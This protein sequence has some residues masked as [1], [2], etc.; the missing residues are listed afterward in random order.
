[1]LTR[2][3]IL[4]ALLAAGLV[5]A[6]CSEQ[7]VDKEPTAQ[8]QSVVVEGSLGSIPAVSLPDGM[9]VTNREELQAIPGFGRELGAG[10]TAIL[11]VTTF[12]GEGTL[13]EGP[14]LGTPKIVTIDRDGVGE[15][16]A[17]TLVGKHEGS[18]IVLLE[19]VQ[20]KGK[21]TTLVTVIDIL[22]TI[23]EGTVPEPVAGMP[24]VELVNDRQQALAMGEEPAPADLKVAPLIVGQGAQVLEGQRVIV[25]FASTHWSTGELIDATE[26][27]TPIAVNLNDVVP[28]MRAGILDQRV[29]SRVLLVIPP[30]QASGTD[31]VV[32]VVDILAAYTPEEGQ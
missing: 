6:G 7:S 5:L 26:P 19:P 10:D 9:N 14:A 20:V 13:I 28:G 27:A 8:V 31:T 24:D 25:T 1:M 3:R 12:D 23:A 30:D 29:G 22:P 16:L 2:S 4:A 32:M 18:R 21:D 11:T 17:E 15:V